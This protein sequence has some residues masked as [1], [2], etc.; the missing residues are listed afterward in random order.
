MLRFYL[1]RLNDENATAKL[2]NSMMQV[3]KI[4]GKF[5]SYWELNVRLSLHQ[6]VASLAL[7]W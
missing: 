6:Q 4:T 5:P 7:G 3:A 2:L 1:R